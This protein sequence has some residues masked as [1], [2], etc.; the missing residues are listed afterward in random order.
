MDSSDVLFSQ[1]P[2][3]SSGISRSSEESTAAVSHIAVSEL[4]S[5]CSAK[6]VSN[7]FSSTCDSRGDPYEDIHSRL[8]A[9]FDD[10]SYV[11][12]PCTGVLETEFST[13]LSP[14]SDQE[15]ISRAYGLQNGRLPN[16][17]Y[18]SHFPSV[19]A[20]IDDFDTTLGLPFD[21]EANTVPLN[22]IQDTKSRHNPE[23]C[24]LPVHITPLVCIQTFLT[25]CLLQNLVSCQIEFYCAVGQM[26][27]IVWSCKEFLFFTLSARRTMSLLRQYLTVL[28]DKTSCRWE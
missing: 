24:E 21:I 8:F 25:D 17:D 14:V 11:N 20:K 4:Q 23:T 19:E 10:G 1:E 27:Q 26:P 3:G 12:M 28:N 7:M 16:W 5:L 13:L 6:R 15:H 22:V 18:D 2:I 9:D